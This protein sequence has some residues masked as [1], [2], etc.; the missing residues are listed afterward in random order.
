MGGSITQKLLTQTI[1]LNPKDIRPI[2][3]LLTNHQ[4]PFTNYYSPI[5][6]L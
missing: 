4:L 5:S 2:E 1:A 3:G 6:N